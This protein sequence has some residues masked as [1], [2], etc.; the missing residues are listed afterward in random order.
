MYLDI[1]AFSIEDQAR[2]D[3]GNHSPTKDLIQDIGRIVPFTESDILR[4][5]DRSKRRERAV[6]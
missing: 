2:D 5:E 3:F 6:K 4:D 1:Q